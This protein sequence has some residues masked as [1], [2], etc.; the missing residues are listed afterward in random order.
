MNS[1]LRVTPRLVARP[2]QRATYTTEATS[3]TKKT[4]AIGGG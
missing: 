4:G 2:V 3:T 1:L